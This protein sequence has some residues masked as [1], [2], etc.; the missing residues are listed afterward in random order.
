MVFPQFRKR[1]DNKSFYK[2]TSFTSFEEIQ[3]VGKRF[4]F[5]VVHAEKYF[6]KFQ[7]LNMLEMDT[8]MY[9][10]SEEEEFANVEKEAIN[11]GA[12]KKTFGLD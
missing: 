6:E 10:M 12:V 5:H 7:I 11:S 1:F 9:L 4:F 8:E 3:L 2:I